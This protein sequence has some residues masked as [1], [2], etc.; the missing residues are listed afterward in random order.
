MLCRIEINKEALLNNFRVFQT[1]TGKSTVMPVLKSNAYGHGLKECWSILKS[2]A[3]T[4]IAV[5]YIS[6][7]ELLR[8]LGFKGRLLVVGPAVESG[9]AKADA[10]ELDL[11]AGNMD[12]LKSWANRPGKCR[13]HV[14]IE[15]GMSR[16]GILP[17]DVDEAVA[18]FLAKKV[19][20]TG[21]CTHF[22]NVEDVTDQSYALHQMSGF[23]TAI[24]KFDAAGF[25][26]I[27]HAAS[28][29]S[30]LIMESSLF[31]LSRV[32]ISLYGVWP[33]KLTKVSYLQL[34]ANV[35]M[36]Q[37]VLSW[38]TEITTLKKVHVGQYIGY[39]CTFRANHEMDIAVLPVGYNEGYPRI[40]GEGPAYVLI[41]GERCPIVGRICMNMMMVDV[42]HTSKNLHVGD[43]VVLIGKSGEETVSAGD[44]A[45]WS[46]TIHYEIFTKLHPDIPRVIV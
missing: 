27:R 18:Y 5:N 39:G 45:N 11:V 15:T 1:K 41:R 40:A 26:T 22:A 28:S 2:A 16:Q 43:E 42:T 4:W 7:A 19:S 33:S 17:E 36:L 35:A 12:L 20:P 10:L 25:K 44:L 38:K 3:P 14:K 37:P 24:A 8:N 31:D 29:A 13:L 30:S 32:G 23:E 21:I 34:N 9:F 46:K 6:E